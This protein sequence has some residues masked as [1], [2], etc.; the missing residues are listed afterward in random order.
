VY[1][2][3][4]NRFFQSPPCPS[5]T[6][7][8][9]G[10]CAVFFEIFRHVAY[11][12]YASHAIRQ[13]ETE[14]I[15]EM[16]NPLPKDRIL[17][18]GCGAG[19]LA[20]SLSRAGRNSVVIGVDT[21]TLD[22]TAAS[23]WKNP[24]CHFLVADAHYLPFRARSF[25]V[26]TSNCVFEHL[27]FPERALRE[28][29]RVGRSGCRVSLTVDSWNYPHPV[30]LRALHARHYAVRMFFS[31]NH[32][33]EIC[34]RAGLEVSQVEFYIRSPIAAVVFLW[35]GMTSQFHVPGLKQLI[36]WADSKER[37]DK[38]FCLALGATVLIEGKIVL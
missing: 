23:G 29:S 11:A 20:F 2:I 21:R 27:E 17:D 5:G 9:L 12:F 15:L 14:L 28:V 35:G 38:G 1:G 7:T 37:D 31:R 18:I 34:E 25:S 30:L 4:V 26:V 22:V 13:L 33:V 32:L 3:S 6:V 16:L 19:N 36:R 10:Q 8:T 24:M